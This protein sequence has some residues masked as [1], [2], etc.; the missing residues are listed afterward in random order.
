MGPL[1][2]KIWRLWAAYKAGSGV[3]IMRFIPVLYVD[4]CGRFYAL[5]TETERKSSE[6]SHLIWQGKQHNAVFAGSDTCT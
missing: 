3:N 6:Q 4:E 2:A 5:H 1:T